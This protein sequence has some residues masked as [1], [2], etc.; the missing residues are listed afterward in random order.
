M[1][2]GKPVLPSGIQVRELSV[3]TTVL[4]FPPQTKSWNNPQHSVCKGFFRLNSHPALLKNVKEFQLYILRCYQSASNSLTE[5]AR[6]S[7]W[8]WMLFALI[9]IS[10]MCG[11]LTS[12]LVLHFFFLTRLLSSFGG[13]ANWHQGL[14]WWGLSYQDQLRFCFYF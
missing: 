5:A 12:Q 9:T 11:I 6:L 2:T 10:L 3:L 1:Q 8:I 13:F 14:W 4:L 7:C